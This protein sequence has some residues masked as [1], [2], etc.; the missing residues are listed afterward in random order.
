MSGIDL[1]DCCEIELQSDFKCIDH[2]PDDYVDSYFLTLNRVVD[3]E[4]EEIESQPVAK[5][6]VWR[7]RIEHA[8]DD[9]VPAEDV[10]DAHS[11]WLE[12]YKFPLQ[13]HTETFESPSD[14]FV[15]QEL[16]V[17][18]TFRGLGIGVLFLKRVVSLLANGCDYALCEPRA[19]RASEFI[20]E[21]WQKTKMSDSD[22]EIYFER[23]G[24]RSVEGTE[25]YRLNLWERIPAP[26]DDS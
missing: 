12:S 5:L 1:F 10:L 22:V 7:V 17:N 11:D 13:Q 16:A 4:G 15:I 20:P 8:F 24:F 6:V 2:E 23:C 18:P 26:S 14:L 9:A 21:D 19:G 25:V 3:E